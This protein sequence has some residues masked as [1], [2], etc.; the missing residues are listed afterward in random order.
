MHAALPGV[1]LERP[2]C[3]CTRSRACRFLLLARRTVYLLLLSKYSALLL[4]P[5]SHQ[6]PVSRAN[7]R[8]PFWKC[9]RQVLQRGR[10]C[11][12]S[13]SSLSPRRRRKLFHHVV[14]TAR[15]FSA[16]SHY[17]NLAQ[18]SV[19]QKAWLCSI[20][21]FTQGR[22]G[23]SPACS[24]MKKTRFRYSAQLP[25]FNL[26]WSLR[27]SLPAKP[28]WHSS[29]T[30]GAVAMAWCS[31]SVTAICSARGVAALLMHT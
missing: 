23:R 1:S 16:S 14:G 9:L 12:G 26:Q 24:A 21:R 28:L 3:T 30:T 6:T 31:A 25:C 4:C 5:P 29:Q 7:R 11:S 17:M 19:E 27:Q 18:S 8:W 10:P 13:Q 20:D 22:R 15:G 2:R